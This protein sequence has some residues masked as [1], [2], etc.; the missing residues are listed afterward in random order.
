[1]LF[2]RLC[3]QFSRGDTIFAGNLVKGGFHALGQ[4]YYESVLAWDAS[5]AVATR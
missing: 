4:G 2:K 1:M 5:E 3:H